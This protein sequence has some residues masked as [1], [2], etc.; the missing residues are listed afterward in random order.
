MS[1]RTLRLSLPGS[2]IVALLSL[3][4]ACGDVDDDTEPASES[5]TPAGTE[6]VVTAEAGEAEQVSVILDWFMIP[7]YS[8]LVLA[9]DKGY[10]D[11]EGIQITIEQGGPGAP[12]LEA[13][14]TGD[15]D[16]YL[17]ALD[18]V[19]YGVVGGMNVRA[20]AAVSHGNPIGV[21]VTSNSPIETWQDLAGKTVGSPLGITLEPRSL[22]DVLESQ[23]VDAGTVK[24]VEVDPAAASA[25]LIAGQFDALIGWNNDSFVRVAYPEDPD[26]RIFEYS[27]LEGWDFFAGFGFVASQR[28]ID[29]NPELVQ[30][31]L[32]AAMRG[33]ADAVADPQAA[34]DAAAAAYP[35]AFLVPEQTLLSLEFL[36]E[37]VETSETEEN[38]L[39]FMADDEW[40]S[41]QE[42]L[43]QYA[44]LEQESPVDS[45]FTNDVLPDEPVQVQR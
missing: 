40:E 12:G 23:G 11:E 37:D 21:I 24:I 29:E 38:G 1:I 28:L 41:M 16:F 10:F 15:Q 3:F 14:D 30:R 36:R 13:V 20:V 4:A 5:T 39:G 22:P 27:E 31:F 2:L 32:R 9:E 45:F 8:P 26:A 17:G 44:D 35:E 33:Y 43:L 25:L 6:R 7:I 19:P 18:D 34:V 42:V